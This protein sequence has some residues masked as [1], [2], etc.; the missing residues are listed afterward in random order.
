MDAF[1]VTRSPPTTTKSLSK[2]LLESSAAY[3]SR[4]PSWSAAHKWTRRQQQV[5]PMLLPSPVPLTKSCSS[6]IIHIPNFFRPPSL[7]DFQR[8][9]KTHPPSYHPIKVYGKLLEENRYSQLYGSFGEERYQE[10]ASTDSASVTRTEAANELSKVTEVVEESYSYSGTSRPF[11]P[12]DPS[13]E[14][15]LFIMHLCT[16][17]DDLVIQLIDEGLV[18]ASSSTIISDTNTAIRQRSYNCCL[19][20][21]YRPEHHIGSHSDDE[22]KMDLSIP[23]MS[24]SWG[25]PRRFLLRP[26]PHVR[27]DALVSPFQEVL[28][29]DGDLLIMGGKCQEEFKHEIPRLRKKDGLVVDRISWTVRRII[30]SQH[31]NSA[32]VK[33]KRDK[34]S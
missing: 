32:G 21:W 18:K 8:I 34:S 31:A 1:V 11:I 7:Q 17:A 13:K 4:I 26:K 20:N 9:W 10:Y 14:E 19:M 12:C 16:V 25:G 3:C 33:R 22:T 30:K 28:L 27:K 2:A 15:E 23:I 24:L 29:Q 6:W 5:R